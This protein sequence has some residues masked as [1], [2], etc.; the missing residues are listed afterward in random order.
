MDKT[1]VPPFRLTAHSWLHMQKQ[2]WQCLTP[3][4]SLPSTDEYTVDLEGLTVCACVHTEGM[5][6]GVLK[7][8]KGLTVSLC[9]CACRGCDSG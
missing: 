8:W 9:V 2:V 7:L 1:S 6:L 5:A 3:A 4:Y